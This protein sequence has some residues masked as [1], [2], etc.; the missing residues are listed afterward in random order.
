M[1]ITFTKDDKGAPEGHTVFNYKAGET[2]DLPEELAMAFVMRH[3]S[4]VALDSRIINAGGDESENPERDTK[5]LK[6]PKEKK[7]KKG[8]R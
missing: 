5:A 1:K 6:E 4:A 7:E 3:G 8:K 2:H